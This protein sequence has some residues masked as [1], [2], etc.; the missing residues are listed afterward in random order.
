MEKK[1]LT[2]RYGKIVNETP[3]RADSGEF[4]DSNSRTD[5]LPS[6]GEQN[7]A[8]NAANNLSVD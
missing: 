4:R 6:A 1:E 2:D 8:N 5:H 3:E 7:Q